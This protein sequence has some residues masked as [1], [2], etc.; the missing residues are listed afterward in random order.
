MSLN[1]VDTFTP[2]H[3]RI[4]KFFNNPKEWCR[5][6]DVEYPY[7]SEGSA[8]KVL[9]YAFPELSRLTDFYSQIIKGL[10]T[11][12]LM[13][14][15]YFYSETDP[16]NIIKS[17]TTSLGKKFINFITSSIEENPNP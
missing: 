13:D 4:L 16:L 15:S 1:F 12:S 3:L 17:R 2:W 6:N 9:V 7:W 10:S 14:D 11:R 5:K 8:S